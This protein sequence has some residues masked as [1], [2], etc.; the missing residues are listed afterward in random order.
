MSRS[1]NGSATRQ[2]PV[3]SYSFDTYSHP[4]ICSARY[5]SEQVDE[6]SQRRSLYKPNSG[7]RSAQ[8]QDLKQKSLLCAEGVL[9]PVANKSAPSVCIRLQTHSK[10]GVVTTAPNQSKASPRRSMGIMTA[11]KQ[12][13]THSSKQ[14][15]WRNCLTKLRI[16]N[17]SQS[18]PS[19]LGFCRS[20][21]LVLCQGT[22]NN[23]S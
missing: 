1:P 8:K 4:A 21:R 13:G 5:C 9:T 11:G 7:N 12:A 23:T 18:I 19:S 15:S 16:C 22:A 3:H 14:N 6:A 17:G 10:I 20:P 2:F